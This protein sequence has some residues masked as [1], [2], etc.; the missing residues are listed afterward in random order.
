MIRRIRHQLIPDS[1]DRLPDLFTKRLRQRLDRRR[2]QSGPQP[3]FLC[4][5][6]HDAQ[7]AV[8]AK[9]RPER[10]EACICGLCSFT[11]PCQR[12]AREAKSGSRKQAGDDAVPGIRSCP[13]ALPLRPS[14]RCTR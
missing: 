10:L 5:Q 1:L 3:E 9:Q 11:R 4:D 2:W 8:G 14:R 13:A 7:A 6:V 12:G